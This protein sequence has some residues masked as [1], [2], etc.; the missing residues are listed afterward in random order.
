MTVR[1]KDYIDIPLT[2]FRG[3]TTHP[4]VIKLDNPAYPAG[5][6][7]AEITLYI[8]EQRTRKIIKTLSST[9]AEIVLDNAKTLRV[10]PFLCEL[11]TG[12][13]L[14]EIVVKYPNTDTHLVARSMYTVTP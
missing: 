13:Y 10:N 14:Y 6:V 3:F 5:F 9:A 12:E 11:Q 8:R 1:F 7:D 4:I 2:A